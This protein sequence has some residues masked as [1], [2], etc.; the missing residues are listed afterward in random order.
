[1]RSLTHDQAILTR[2]SPPTSRPSEC[3]AACPPNP[4]VYARTL[5]AAE[6]HG[7]GRHLAGALLDFGVR[8]WEAGQLPY[9]LQTTQEA[10][11]AFR[12][13]AADEAE[14]AR[15]GLA[16]ALHNLALSHRALGDTDRAVA[17]AEAVRIRRDLVTTDLRFQVDLAFSLG[18]LGQAYGDLG[19]L[20]EARTALNEAEALTRRLADADH[21]AGQTY[22]QAQRSSEALPVLQEALA[23]RREL[24]ATD[25]GAQ[26]TALAQTLH[27]LGTLFCADQM[28][29]QAV[30]LLEEAATLYLHARKQPPAAGAPGSSRRPPPGPQRQAPAVRLGS[31]QPG[32]GKWQV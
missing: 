20:P 13:L 9:A 6:P 1:M 21:V 14:E 5:A 15:P 30:P 29:P 26:T 10:V 18:H 25:P 16:Q 32:R 27:N 7:H 23:I 19:C 12:D 28:L 17:A 2:P 8:L 4:G 31:L 24:V 22:A 3:S 11:A